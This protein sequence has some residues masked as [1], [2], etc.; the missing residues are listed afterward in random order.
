M[1]KSI[2][3]KEL[4]KIL[5]VSA[6]TVSKALNDSY[7]ISE[8]T[9]KKVEE[10]AKRYNYRPNRAALNLKSGKTNTIGVVLPSIKDFFLVRALRGIESVLADTDYNIIITVTNESY[11]KE[12]K[13]VET[14]VNGLV[15][16][17]IIA[18]TEETQLKQDFRHLSDISDNIDLIMF[19][20]VDNSVKCDKILVNDFE[21]VQKAVRHLKFKGASNIALASSNKNL[22]DENARLLGY[23]EAIKDEQEPLIVKG[24]EMYIENEF[25][26]LFDEERVD[27]IIA[28]DEEASLAAFRIASKRGLLEDRK[29]LMIGYAGTKISEHLKPSLSTVD[30]HGKRLG[31]TTAKQLLDRLNK[32]ETKGDKVTVIYS[33]LCERATTQTII[34]PL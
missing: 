7:E 28:L 12:V 15:D 8:A 25:H 21:A 18:V 2:T 33:S 30:Q 16:G 26:V 10:A 19:D 23:L 3:L 13:A 20:R 11:E 4:A 17:I 29:L 9:K 32:K 31:R 6:S 27:G 34:N 14:L 5:D 22:S 1:K 24:N